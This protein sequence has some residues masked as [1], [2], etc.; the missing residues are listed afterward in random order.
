MFS[1]ERISSVVVF[2]FVTIPLNLFKNM[3]FENRFLICFFLNFKFFLRQKVKSY[4][5][6]VISFRKFCIYILYFIEKLPFLWI[7]I[8][9]VIYNLHKALVFSVELDLPIYSRY[10]RYLQKAIEHDIC[11]AYIEIHKNCY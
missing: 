2:P 5:L 1:R 4:E 3:N 6:Y 11:V 9:Q 8:I 10:C 7:E